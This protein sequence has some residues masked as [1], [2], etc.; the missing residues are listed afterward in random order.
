[1]TI[2]CHEG[3]PPHSF[4]GG[5]IVSAAR[6][7][8]TDPQVDPLPCPWCRVEVPMA[9]ILGL[10]TAAAQVE[11]QTYADMLE[12]AAARDIPVAVARQHGGACGLCF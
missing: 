3:E 7:R 9:N 10:M 12:D 2:P 6:A 1:V 8:L 5:C 4:H 11:A